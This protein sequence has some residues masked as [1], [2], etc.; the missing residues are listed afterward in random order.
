MSAKG[1]WIC[2]YCG[3]FNRA[4]RVTCVGCDGSRP[5]PPTVV[6]EPAAQ[7]FATGEIFYVKEVLPDGYVYDE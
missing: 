5:A 3:R 4:S 6:I 7:T 2:K 1:A